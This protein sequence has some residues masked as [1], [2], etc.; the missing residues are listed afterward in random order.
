MHALHLHTLKLYNY[1][2]YIFKKTDNLI[3][4]LPLYI[5]IV[6]THQL[7]FSIIPTDNSFP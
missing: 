7:L 6:T 4:Y 1:F 3:D 2:Y 5:L